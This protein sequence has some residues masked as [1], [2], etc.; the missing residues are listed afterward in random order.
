MHPGNL[1]VKNFNYLL[2]EDNIAK[3]PLT[4]RDQSKLLIYKNRFIQ[5]D[6]YKNIADYLPE[7]ALLVFNNT[8]VIEARILFQKSSGGIIEIFALEPHRQYPD[9]TTAMNI[10][11]KIWWKCLIG[12]AGKWKRG[13]ILEWEIIENGVS[14]HLWARIVERLQGNF[15]IEFTWHP[16]SLNF[17]GILHRFGVMPIPPYLKRETII[18]DNERYQTIYAKTDGSVAA[19]TAGL[20]FTENIF[21]S[22]QSK[23]IQAAF[24]TL[25]VGA[26][27]FMPVKSETLSGHHM[28]AEFIQVEMAFIQKLINQ[29]DNVFA[30][31]TTSLRTLESLYWMGVKCSGNPFISLEELEIKQWEVY[32]QLEEHVIPTASALRALL[33]WMVRNELPVLIIKTSMLIAPPY[34]PKIIRGLITNFHQPNSTLLLLVS[35]L[36]GEE[37][38]KVYEY[39]LKNDFRFLSYGDGSLLFV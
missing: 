26:G 24:L 5:Q 23:N 34:R 16:A 29:H 3:F 39:A 25:H 38:T 2:P 19:P 15:T 6:T 28:H 32:E 37:W 20:H 33:H 36:I 31:G 11:G 10:C 8:R 14:I 9:I 35:A 4:E 13:Q 12:G 27:T 22:L 30:V 7:K 1:S 21:Y 18:S 17:A